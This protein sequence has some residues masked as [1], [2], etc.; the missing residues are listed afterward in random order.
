L[1]GL[2]NALEGK[3][4]NLAASGKDTKRL[5]D[6]IIPVLK[7]I[8]K[9]YRNPIMHPEMKLDE[10]DAIDVFDNAKA[11]IASTLRDIHEGNHLA[12][13]KAV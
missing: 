7:R 11:A 10:N 5:T 4:Q 12:A 1:G 9:T 6:E 8:V 3:S 13:W 2:V